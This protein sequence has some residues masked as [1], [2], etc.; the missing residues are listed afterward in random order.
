MVIAMT[1][2]VYQFR[3]QLKDIEPLIWRR[4]VIPSSYSFWYLH[5][6]IQDAMGWLDYHLHEFRIP[7]KALGIVERIGIP[8][9]DDFYD[10]PG[11]KPGWQL[12][13]SDY[14]REIGERIEY[15]SAKRA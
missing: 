7:L 11:P 15:E 1:K 3:I 5:C 6:A 8:F 2:K 4:I 14:I 13:V 9:E 12:N 10:E